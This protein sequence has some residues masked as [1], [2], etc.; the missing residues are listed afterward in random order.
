MAV[1]S[2]SLVEASRATLCCGAGAY[3]R[4]FSC[5]RA[6]ALGVRAQQLWCRALVVS[7]HVGSSWTRDRTSVSCTGRRILNHWTTRLQ[8]AFSELTWVKVPRA[9]TQDGFALSFPVF[10]FLSSLSPGLYIPWHQAG[11]WGWG[12]SKTIGSHLSVPSKSAQLHG[13]WKHQRGSREPQKLGRQG[14]LVHGQPSH[15]CILQGIETLSCPVLPGRSGSHGC[16]NSCPA[17]LLSCCII[18]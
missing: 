15:S 16:R 3:Y 5:C 18:H 17:P 1:H 12:S 13:N 2:L 14:I 10:L 6:Q 11:F 9:G 8:G 7:W 4:G